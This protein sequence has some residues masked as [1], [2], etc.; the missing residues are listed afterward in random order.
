MRTILGLE[1]GDNL[2][3]PTKTLPFSTLEVYYQLLFRKITGIKMKK[4]NL[5][6]VDMDFQLADSPLSRIIS[7]TELKNMFLILH[8]IKSQDINDIYQNMP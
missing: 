1:E 7:S 3:D 6:R 8:F 5:I 2:V 4:I